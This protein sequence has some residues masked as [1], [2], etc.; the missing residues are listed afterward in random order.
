MCSF[1]VGNEYTASHDEP[2]GE[3][4]RLPFQLGSAGCGCQPGGTI[5]AGLSFLSDRPRCKPRGA[6]PYA[7]FPGAR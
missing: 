1:S 5:S 7:A 6:Y 4:K 2:S 3:T